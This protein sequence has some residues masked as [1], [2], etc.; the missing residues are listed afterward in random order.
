MGLPPLPAPDAQ[1]SATPSDN[2]SDKPTLSYIRRTRRYSQFG[3]IGVRRCI[4]L[5]LCV[6]KGARLRRLGR[7]IGGGAAL[8][9]FFVVRVG[10]LGAVEGIQRTW[11]DL[12]R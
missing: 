1:P 3:S 2:I 12:P 10:Q 6:A 5:R 4:T 8:F 11:W 9:S 7:V